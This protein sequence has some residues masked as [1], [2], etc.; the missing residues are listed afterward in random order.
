VE[1]RERLRRGKR[2]VEREVT[3]RFGPTQD[4]MDVLDHPR[5]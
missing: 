2:I 3:R 4:A 1:E 5:E